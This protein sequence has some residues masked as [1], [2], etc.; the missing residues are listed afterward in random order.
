VDREGGPVVDRP[1]DRRERRLQQDG[2]AD[3]GRALHRFERG[4]RRERHSDPED[5]Q[6]RCEPGQRSGGGDVERAAPRGWSLAHAH[7]GAEGAGERRSGNEE[8]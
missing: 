6:Q 2:M 5:G 8:R 7:E 1:V 4:W 3:G